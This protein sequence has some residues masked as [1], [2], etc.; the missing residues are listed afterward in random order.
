MSIAVVSTIADAAHHEVLGCFIEFALQKGLGV[1][2]YVPSYDPENWV[3]WYGQCVRVIGKMLR[4]CSSATFSDIEAVQYNMIVIG[5]AT[6]AIVDKLSDIT[7]KR[8]IIYNHG[9]SRRT[10][11]LCYTGKAHM[12]FTR[13]ASTT[14]MDKEKC[15]VPANT[16]VSRYTPVIGDSADVIRIVIIGARMNYFDRTLVQNVIKSGKV[17][18]IEWVTRKRNEEM[19]GE[20]EYGGTLVNIHLQISAADLH[21]LVQECDYVLI[22]RT[23]SG[24]YSKHIMSGAIPIALNTCT[25]MIM[26]KS[27]ADAYPKLNT[28]SFFTSMLTDGTFSSSIRKCTNVVRESILQ[29]R[30][31]YLETH[32]YRIIGDVYDNL[33]ASVKSCVPIQIP[34]K[35]HFV[36]LAKNRLTP[37]FPSKY[38]PNVKAWQSLMPEFTVKVWHDNDIEQLFESNSNLPITKEQY[39]TLTPHISKCDLARLLVTL[40]EGGYYMDLDFLSISSVLNLPREHSDYLIVQEI[41]EHNIHVDGQVTNGF[42]GFV[43]KHPMNK[44]LIQMCIEN[45]DDCVMAN[46]GP[47]AW[48]RAIKTYN[49]NNNN[50]PIK[51]SNEC[52]SSLVMPLTNKGILTEAYNGDIP[53]VTM[54]LWRDGA[55]WG[56]HDCHKNVNMQ[57]GLHQKIDIL[58]PENVI[59]M[60]EEE[61]ENEEEE[62]MEEEEDKNIEPGILAAIIC[63]A[64]LLFMS[65]LY[66]I[67]RPFLSKSPLIKTHLAAQVPV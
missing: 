31:T 5:S 16:F 24:S 7:L 65:L 38:I 25:P 9:D 42:F 6:D 58:Y 18:L 44:A 66:I 52:V 57:M 12:L 30:E 40:V 19:L 11:P 41:P 37:N 32:A 62:V 39:N 27:I 45:K 63:L 35:L 64:L 1:T 60:E 67:L 36:W 47:I 15:F 46:T 4:I 43:S 34:Q 50:D 33:I 23:S 17:I 3:G 26:V 13:V 29:L 10:G 59:A 51:V 53:A 55:H 28:A 49:N 61:D 2:L 21:E 48:S 8:T 56:E 22:P 20:L 54:T 14:T